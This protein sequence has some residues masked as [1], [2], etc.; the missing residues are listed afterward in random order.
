MGVDADGWKLN[1]VH[2][3]I[4]CCVS[5]IRWPEENWKE[6]YTKYL[7]HQHAYF[8]SYALNVAALGNIGYLY[9]H[10]LPKNISQS[11]YTVCE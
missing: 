9:S 7:S 10:K 3:S 5:S 1:L 6:Y 2:L 11:S 8:V 4:T